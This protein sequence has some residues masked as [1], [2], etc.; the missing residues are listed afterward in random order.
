MNLPHVRQDFNYINFSS[1]FPSEKN[2]VK[3]LREVR[4]VNNGLR[5]ERAP[6][7]QTG[8]AGSLPTGRQRHNINRT[9][10]VPILFAT[11]V[12][13]KLFDKVRSVRS[14]EQPLCRR[15]ASQKCEECTKNSLSC[16][17]SLKQTNL[18]SMRYCDWRLVQFLLSQIM[19]T[20]ISINVFP[21]SCLHGHS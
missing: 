17:K 6:S 11:D 9:S 21:W 8:Y 1:N 3:G 5:P 14:A 10:S 16:P 18:I 20:K 2:G 15:V 4:L 7:R 13:D 12:T 19:Q